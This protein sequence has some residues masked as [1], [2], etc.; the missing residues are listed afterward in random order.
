M[1]G[2]GT[3]VPAADSPAHMWAEENSFLESR[4]ALP[5]VA[6]NKFACQCEFG[7]SATV[8]ARDLAAWMC[9]GGARAARHR[10]LFLLHLHYS[11]PLMPL[12]PARSRRRALP[13]SPP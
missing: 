4:P 7:V 5:V 13:P 3:E 9:G 2:V 10:I 8:G 6:M 11:Y 1:G 12:K